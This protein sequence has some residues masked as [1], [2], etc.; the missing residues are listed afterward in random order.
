MTRPP[1]ELNDI[2]M[3]RARAALRQKIDP[4][5][6]GHGLEIRELTTALAIGN[7]ADPAKGRIHITYATG[8]VSLR[9]VTWDYLGPLQGSEPRDDPDHEPGVTA[10]TIIT[11]LT[12]DTPPPAI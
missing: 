4:L 1:H 7:P 8:D 6:R 10:A 12:E 5:L 9:R 3:C 11:T 2:D